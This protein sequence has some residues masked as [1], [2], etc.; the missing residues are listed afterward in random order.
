M[1]E[2]DTQSGCSSDLVHADDACEGSMDSE[3]HHISTETLKFE[4]QAAIATQA[5]LLSQHVEDTDLIE[6]HVRNVADMLFLFCHQYVDRHDA[7]AGAS[8]ADKFVRECF[9]A[10][11]GLLSNRSFD[12]P[13]LTLERTRWAL[14]ARDFKTDASE[15]GSRKKPAYYRPAM[16]CFMSSV[17]EIVR[18]SDACDSVVDAGFDLLDGITRLP[19]GEDDQGLGRKEGVIGG[20]ERRARLGGDRHRDCHVHGVPECELETVARASHYEFDAVALQELC[21]TAFESMGTPFGDHLHGSD[22]SSSDDDEKTGVVACRR[23]TTLRATR[24]LLNYVKP[25]HAD[26]PYAERARRM[27]RAGVL[28]K[29]LRRIEKLVRRRERGESRRAPRSD[30]GLAG[31]GSERLRGGASEDTTTSN[32]FEASI[33]RVWD[34]DDEEDSVRARRIA[35][36]IDHPLD[37]RWLQTCFALFTRLLRVSTESLPRLGAL[38]RV[39]GLQVARVTRLLS[40]GPAFVPGV[41]GVFSAREKRSALQASTAFARYRYKTLESY[42]DAAAASLVDAALVGWRDYIRDHCAPSIASKVPFDLAYDEDAR[43]KRRSIGERIPENASEE[44]FYRRAPKFDARLTAADVGAA[45]RDAAEMFEAFRGAPTGSQEW[46]GALRRRRAISREAHDA[47]VDLT[48]LATSRGMYSLGCSM[49]WHAQCASAGAVLHAAT[50]NLECAAKPASEE[51]ST[52][53]A[54]REESG[55]SRGTPHLVLAAKELQ[56]R[57]AGSCHFRDAQKAWRLISSTMQEHGSNP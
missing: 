46:Y 10:M 52:R 24:A 5:R 50:F 14:R 48:T 28:E 45:L 41:R 30:D 9:L 13:Q 7:F 35:E 32:A 42:E 25:T 38:E 57:C 54:G 26:P 18:G 4:A 47:L 51:T 39:L 6:L 11:H 22:D 12:T 15:D 34:V 36:D 3:S 1:S 53:V 49:H 17:I 29:V 37:A 19:R 40:R 2:F 31:G 33:P 20:R 8:G 23:A 55:L 27:I 43:A 21:D 56:D 44:T 16:Q